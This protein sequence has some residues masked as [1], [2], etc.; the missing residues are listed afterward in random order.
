MVDWITEQRYYVHWLVVDIPADAT[1][2][3]EGASTAAR[4]PRGT[5]E[6]TPYVG[7]FPPSGRHTYRFTLYALRTATLVLPGAASLERFTE[8]AEAD[9]LATATLAGTFTAS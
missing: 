8:A 5:R 4:M 3:T 7:P 6:I 2:L 1:A 9:A